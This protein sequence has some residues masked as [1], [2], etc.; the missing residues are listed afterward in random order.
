MGN[1]L[2]KVQNSVTTTYGYDD[3]SALRRGGSITITIANDAGAWSFFYHQVPTP[4]LPVG[5][6]D[7]FVDRFFASS[8]AMD[9]LGFGAL[10]IMHIRRTRP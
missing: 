9:C 6:V 3:A 2:T 8:W 7:F 10:S 4:P 1:R 5:R